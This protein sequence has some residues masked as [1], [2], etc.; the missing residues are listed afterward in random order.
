[1]ISFCISEEKFG[2]LEVKTYTTQ[3]AEG[4]LFFF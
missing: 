1:M 4:K 3:D 2:S